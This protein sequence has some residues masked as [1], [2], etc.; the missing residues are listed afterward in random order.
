[1]PTRSVMSK[2]RLVEIEKSISEF[3]PEKENLEKII[4]AI[5]DVLKFDP[6]LK[7]YTKEIGQQHIQ[8]RK[9]RAEE[10]GVSQYVL[11]NKAKYS[12]KST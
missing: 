6:E 5:C 4:L 9:Q 12:K 7:M 10:L 11:L 8:R 2:K 3:I 1:M